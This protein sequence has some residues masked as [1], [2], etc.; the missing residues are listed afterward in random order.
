MQKTSDE[1]RAGAVRTI[2]VGRT[3]ERGE[4]GGHVGYGSAAF[5]YG[6]QLHDART[7]AGTT[8]ILSVRLESIERQA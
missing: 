5:H 2:V 3:V 1:A 6:E 4:R 8:G 7:H